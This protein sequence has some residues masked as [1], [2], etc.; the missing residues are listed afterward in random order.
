MKT[1]AIAL[2]LAFCPLGASAATVSFSPA[3]QNVFVG[4]QASVDLIATNLGRD[5]IG[6]FDFKVEY[7]STLLNLQAVFFGPPLG[8]ALDQVLFI[9]PNPGS[10]GLAEISLLTPEELEALQPNDPVLLVT[11]LFTAL[12]PGDSTLILSASPQVLSDSFGGTL[13][14]T[15]VDGLISIQA[16]PEPATIALSGLSLIGLAFVR[17]RR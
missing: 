12:A 13:S 9:D 1:I 10:V 2:C 6:A 4:Q 7:D 11:L 15:T 16:V 3:A 5:H 17:R 8:P 14:V